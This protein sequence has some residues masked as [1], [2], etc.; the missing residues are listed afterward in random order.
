MI[1]MQICY[2]FKISLAIAAMLVVIDFK[3]LFPEDL[4]VIFYYFRH[5]ARHVSAYFVY[6]LL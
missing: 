2:Y 4:V 1:W 3:S 6:F 5:A